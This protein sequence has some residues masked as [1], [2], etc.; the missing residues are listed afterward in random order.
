MPTGDWLDI[1]LK[2]ENA[3]SG[4]DRGQRNLFSAW[5]IALHPHNE[6]SSTVRV[7][8][9]QCIPPV[10]FTVLSQLCSE[11]QIKLQIQLE[12]QVQLGGV[13]TEVSRVWSF[14]RYK[15]Q[16]VAIP[17]KMQT[18]YLSDMH[19]N[20]KQWKHDLHI[21]NSPLQKVHTFCPDNMIAE[22][23]RVIPQ[24]WKWKNQLQGEETTSIFR[25]LQFN[26]DLLPLA[27]NCQSHGKPVT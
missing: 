15:Q 27:Q 20:T 9:L 17:L 1:G 6:H 26:T 11:Q 12:L 3:F 22:A 19:P 21:P 8:H 14:C 24:T 4:T 5:R 10:P 16:T 18:S 2:V 13:C 23:L 7:Q 25:N